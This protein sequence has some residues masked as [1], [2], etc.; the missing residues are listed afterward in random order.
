[1]QNMN[2]FLLTSIKEGMIYIVSDER[3]SGSKYN[4]YISLDDGRRI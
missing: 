2:K 3:I 4:P 1:M